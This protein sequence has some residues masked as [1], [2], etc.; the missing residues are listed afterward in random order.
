VAQTLRALHNRDRIYHCNRTPP[1]SVRYQLPVDISEESLYAL[2]GR[3]VL[4]TLRRTV[5]MRCRIA[6]HG[7][8]LEETELRLPAP[9]Q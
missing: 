6:A 9:L 8:P 3:D 2:L 1:P 5:T 4:V 7:L